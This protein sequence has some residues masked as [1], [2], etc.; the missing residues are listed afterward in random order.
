MARRTKRTVVLT[1]ACNSAWCLAAVESATSSRTRSSSRDSANDALDLDLKMSRIGRVEP[2]DVQVW[3]HVAAAIAVY[4]VQQ[5]CR[6]VA[7]IGLGVFDG[8]LEQVRK[9]D[10][11]MCLL[12]KPT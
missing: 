2:D 8:V 12:D 1:S 11:S 9:R 5:I 4:D 7:I 6:G 3:K 10:S